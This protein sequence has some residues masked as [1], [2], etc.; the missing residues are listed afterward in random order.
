MHSPK[1][2]STSVV[3]L[4]VAVLVAA[5]LTAAGVSAMRR[6]T[7]A[8]HL[9]AAETLLAQGDFRGAVSSYEA[10]LAAGADRARVE[11]PLAQARAMAEAEATYGEVAAK[12]GADQYDLAYTLLARIPG[13]SPLFE[14][15]HQLILDGMTRQTARRLSEN[16]N[17]AKDLEA[18]RFV[19]SSPAG[20]KAIL[21][22]DYVEFEVV[23]DAVCTLVHE[24]P[25]GARNLFPHRIV[26][27][28]DEEFPAAFLSP[29]G[30]ML[31]QGQSL[32]EPPSE[33]RLAWPDGN[34]GQLV[35]W[36]VSPGVTM[37]AAAY[38][39]RGPTG[40]DPPSVS[41]HVLDLTTLQTKLLSRYM[42]GESFPYEW[43]NFY[44]IRFR[45]DGETSLTYS[46]LDGP[47][48]REVTWRR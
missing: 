3:L 19:L 2:R 35:G 22:I 25:S 9:D 33:P 36:S 16:W 13:E 18:M 46:S 42:I 14:R 45:W 11:G 21:T 39:E 6:A 1:K 7:I 17:V 30:L 40:D 20:D 38:L 8:R 37:A 12:V 48:P 15:A 24:S 4:L 23:G 10:A 32:W 43:Y 41:T 5:C 34:N 27:V 31:I 44:P 47:Y 29:S 26:L 28:S